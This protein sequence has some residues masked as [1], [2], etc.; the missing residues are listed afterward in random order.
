MPS[1]PQPLAPAVMPC[2]STSSSSTSFPPFLCISLHLLMMSSNYSSSRFTTRMSCLHWASWL[3]LLWPSSHPQFIPAGA[4]TQSPK[5]IPGPVPSPA[6]PCCHPATC[7]PPKTPHRTISHV[8]DRTFL[9][10]IFFLV[11]A[12]CSLDFQTSWGKTISFIEG[13]SEKRSQN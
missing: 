8:L 3:L 1:L 12:C 5:C 6:H 11:E 2:F 4:A 7:A 10:P 13:F 9:P